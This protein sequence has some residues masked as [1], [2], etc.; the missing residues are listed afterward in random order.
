MTKH[1]KINRPYEKDSEK[2]PEQRQTEL[3]ER[4][5]EFLSKGG[6]V[7]KLPPGEPTQEQLKSWKI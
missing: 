2:S 4:M 6:V 1:P 5:K 7:E 3:N